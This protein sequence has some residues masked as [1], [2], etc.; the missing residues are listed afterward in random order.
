MENKLAP[1]PTFLERSLQI[2]LL[3]A[4]ALASVAFQGFEYGTVHSVYHIPIIFDYAH[5]AEG[6]SDA[7]HQSLDY[8]VSGVYPI[9]SLFVTEYNIFWVSLLF[10]IAIRFFNIF[11]MWK[12]VSLIIKNQTSV[13]IISSILV[14]SLAS[15]SF[16]SHS[17]IG[18]LFVLLSWY[19]L[20][21]R[22]YLAASAILGAAFN[23]YAYVAVWGGVIAGVCMLSSL[24]HEGLK[25]AIKT[26][27]MMAGLFILFA[28]PTLLWILKSLATAPPYEP[29][30]F[31]GFLRE[32]WP[33][34]TFIDVQWKNI[35][36]LLL[37][38]MTAFTALFHIRLNLPLDKRAPMFAILTAFTGIIVFGM[39]L[40]YVTDSRL[41][42]DLFPLEERRYV[43]AIMAIIIASWC[44]I[45]FQAA[46]PEEKARSIIALT[47]LLSGNIILL[48]TAI[49]LDK[50]FGAIS[51]WKKWAPLLLLVM[52]AAHATFGAPPVQVE[53][54]GTAAALILIFQC[55]LIACFLPKTDDYFPRAL[56]LIAAALLGVLPETHDSIFL[57]LIFFVYFALALYIAQRNYRLILIAVI[58]VSLLMILASAKLIWLGVAATA[59]LL[60][61]PAA[62]LVPF[63][64]KYVSAVKP[65]GS[66]LLASLA[67]CYL[68]FGAVQIGVRGGLS[69]DPQ[70]DRALKDTQLWARSH[71]PPHTVFLPVGVEGFSTLSRRPVWIDWKI[72]AMVMWA[73][74]TYKIWSTRWVQLKPVN[75][76]AEAQNLARRENIGFIVFSKKKVA[77]DG[78]AKSCISYE[79]ELYWI[80]QPC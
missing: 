25:A 55:G 32:Y 49:L 4:A 59:F 24:K 41:L 68:I 22:Q 61:L 3:F 80:M 12:I 23:I 36:V 63:L 45:A 54:W 58:I 74:D 56:L 30:S 33:Y 73:P 51:A 44:G 75:S 39:I 1:T 53:M 13:L 8:F 77:P 38:I 64:Q 46:D 6:P 50:E 48:L 57:A 35:V 34:H 11:I 40:P 37:S 27:C 17:E 9:L 71:T 47:G 67:I 78:V 14:Y 66:A 42:L 60:P 70:A 28:S 62:R 2:F 15:E 5:S 16:F 7:F 69:P 26:S 43:P 19:F 21:K 65:S 20:F 31:R 79:N 52:G 10:H 18:P 29:F 76:V 72:G